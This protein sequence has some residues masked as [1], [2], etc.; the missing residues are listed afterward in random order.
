MKNWSKMLIGIIMLSPV[1]AG[2]QSFSETALA[3]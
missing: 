3:F 2:A 1:A